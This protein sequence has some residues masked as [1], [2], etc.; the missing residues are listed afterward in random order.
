[1]AI[2]LNAILLACLIFAKA[3]PVAAQCQNVSFKDRSNLTFGQLR[4]HPEIKSGWVTISPD[5]TLRA[6]RGISVSSNSRWS[7]ATVQMNLPMG[8]ET[9]IRLQP[10]TEVDQP[11]RL[12]SLNLEVQSTEAIITKVADDIFSVTFEGLGDEQS[13]SGSVKLIVSGTLLLHSLPRSPSQLAHRL[14]IQ[15][16]GT[17]SR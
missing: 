16:V 2:R 4:Y 12:S 11:V 14:Q 17:I 15:C 1:M 7:P 6:S 3:D 8:S 13:Q 10:L 5:S 9:L